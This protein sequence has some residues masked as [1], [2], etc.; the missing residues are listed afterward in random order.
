MDAE[1]NPLQDM[2]H[3][4]RAPLS[5][6]VVRLNRIL[7]TASLDRQVENE[8]HAVRAL[9]HKAQ[10]VVG[11]VSLYDL[12]QARDR[13]VHIHATAVEASHLIRILRECA[14]DT[15]VLIDP[16]REIRFILDLES[17]QAFPTLVVDLPLFEQAMNCLLDNAAK[18]SY[19][20][21]EVRIYGSTRDAYASVCV[22]N[23]GLPISAHEVELSM[24]RGWRGETARMVVGEGSGIGLWI[25]DHIM[26]AHGGHLLVTP[27]GAEGQT[28]VGLVFPAAEKG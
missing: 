10:R 7:E 4:L 28:Q 23:V 13:G 8:I 5:V 6:A 22:A 16:R 2:T 27:T 25:V 21:S 12:V 19:S 11:G 20:A 18:Y 17:F 1:H 15:Q 26:R 24:E 9:C 3:Q 14:E